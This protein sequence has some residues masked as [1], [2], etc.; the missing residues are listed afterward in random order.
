VEDILTV[1]T[2]A[3]LAASAMFVAG[4]VAARA[5]DTPE[6]P[7][8]LEARFQIAAME[9]V[10]EQAVQLGAS[11]VNAQLQAVAPDMVFM[12]GAA[13]ARGFRLENYGMFFDVDVPVMRRSLQWTFRVLRQNDSNVAL[14]VQDLRRKVAS[15]GDAALRQE[16]ER[17]VR[18]IERGVPAIRTA[19]AVSPQGN[20]P[21]VAQESTSQP[22]PGGGLIDDPNQAYTESVKNA[23][24]NAMLEYSGKFGLAPTDWLTVAARDQ[25]GARRQTIDPYGVTTIVLRIRGADLEA[26]HSRQIN[27]AEARSRFDIREY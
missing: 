3:L 17:D 4:V 26:F 23:L 10:L 15:I 21:V 1:R 19:S 27:I 24:M 8:Q 18:R 5:Q 2:R 16:L 9:S 7:E 22:S 14:A 11:H 13:R 25:E 6:R 12:T 20:E